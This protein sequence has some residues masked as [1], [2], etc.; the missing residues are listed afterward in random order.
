M[1]INYDWIS[2]NTAFL[3]LY[4]IVFTANIVFLSH[5]VRLSLFFTNGIYFAFY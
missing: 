1:K 4:S 2:L 5:F 3:T